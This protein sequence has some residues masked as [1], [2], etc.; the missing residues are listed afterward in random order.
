MSSSLEEEINQFYNSLESTLSL[1]P[2]EELKV[3]MKD[4][5]THLG[6]KNTCSEEVM[7]RYGYDDKNERGELFIEFHAKYNLCITNIHF[8]QKES[9]KWTWFAHGFQYHHMIDLILIEK[10]WLSS[11]KKIGTYQGADI[12]SDHSL[13]ICRFLVRFNDNKTKV[14]NKILGIEALQHPTLKEKF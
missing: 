6:G 1:I 5:N 13:V 8:Q 3:I 12:G 11:I 7:G 14:Q 4:W 10:H 2:K 9:R